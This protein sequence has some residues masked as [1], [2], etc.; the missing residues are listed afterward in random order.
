[1]PVNKI[2]NG[3]EVDIV[4]VANIGRTI[5]TR[6]GMELENTTDLI[7]LGAM[8]YITR[9]KDIDA[10]D[11]LQ[12]FVDLKTKDY[13]TKGKLLDFNT[14]NW[15]IIK[16]FSNAAGQKEL[17]A[18]ALH[19]YPDEI[20]RRDYGQS[21]SPDLAMLVTKTLDLQPE[22]TVLDLCS[23]IG[24]FLPTATSE[25]SVSE[26]VGIEI[27]NDNLVI[28][29]VRALISNY[30]FTVR[31]GDA[32]TEDYQD[33]EA[34]KVF[35]HIP[36]GVKNA[37]IYEE[38]YPRL[39]EQLKGLRPSQKLDWAYTLSAICN[40]REGGKTIVVATDNML[41]AVGRDIMLRKRLTD[42]GRLEAVI[43]LP[44]GILA[45]CNVRINLLVF[46]ENN[47]VVNMVDASEMG[48]KNKMRTVLT[49]DDIDQ[50][51]AWYEQKTDSEHNKIIDLG[52]LEHNDYL[53]TPSTY[54]Q[55]ALPAL[56]N[57]EKLG[58]L[59]EVG[60]GGNIK[61]ALLDEWASDEPTEYQY[62]MLKHID[63]NEVADNLPYLKEIDEKNEKSLLQAGDLLIS[64]TA[65]FKVAIMPNTGTKV[66]ANG[67]LYYLRFKSDKINPVYAM[68]F[69]NSERGQQ[70]LAAVAKGV[71][72]SMISGKDLANIEIPVIPMEKQLEMVKLYEKLSKKLRQLREQEKDVMDKMTVLMNG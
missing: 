23:G 57:P 56:E 55:E 47:K 12:K 13:L 62:I 63:N 16:E 53:W 21:T 14:H 58:C 54:F 17:L 18:V 45:W 29:N 4:K 10:L 31:K 70:S 49:M 52:Q 2:N 24:S 65:P 22:D 39:Q 7:I 20:S 59:A 50:I 67:N 34:N 26:A 61:S 38:L 66:L 41:F 5:A 43:A 35:S 46:S 42:E 28:A 68:M 44:T 69:L 11:D 1:M 25:K 15:D 3:V 71:A 40:Q 30:S 36:L 37:G 51:V 33:I 64:R 9:E 6:H 8:S 48:T 72:L 27:N 32:L 19:L 60:R